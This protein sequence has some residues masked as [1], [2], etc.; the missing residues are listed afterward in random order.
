MSGIAARLTKLLVLATLALVVTASGG[1]A[2]GPVRTRILGV[3]PHLSH[4]SAPVGHALPKAGAIRAVA[5]ATLTFDAN[6][7]RLINQYF[8]DVAAASGRTDNVYSVA[9]Q[10]FDNPG[11]VHIQYESTFGGAAISHDPL[12]PNGCDDG[13]DTYCLTD[14]QL[15]EEIQ[16]VLTAKAWHGDTSALNHMFF[17]MTPNGV[18]SCEFAGAASN[19]N[20]CSTNFFCAYHNNFVDSSGEQVIYANEPYMGPLPPGECTAEGIPSLR[21]Q[22]FPNNDVDAET[23]INTISHEHNEA[24]TDPLGNA[25]IAADTNENGDLCAYIF[26]TQLGGTPGID[27]YN[28]V[29]N[30]H[31]YDLQQ[32]YS[33]TDSGCIQRPN[34]T[35]SAANVKEQLPYN[36][37]PVMHT[38]TTYAIYWLPTPGNTSLPV[39]TGSALV[40]HTL[41]TSAGA[42]NGGAT[43]FHDQWQRCSGTSCVNI[44]GATATTYKLTAADGGHIVRSSVSATNVNGASAPTASAATAV[45]IDVPAATSLP[46]ISGRARVGKKLSGSHG[47]WTYSPASFNVQWLRCN[48]HGGHC[49]SIH[50]AT[51]STYKLTKHDAGHRL[52]LRVTAANA[53]GS[54]VALSKPSARVP[55][56]KHH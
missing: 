29:I 12:P 6:Y 1:N 24:I 32:E 3:V 49:S 19:N 53:A 20:P 8:K 30:G 2:A 45:V 7:E 18:G 36:K 39:V 48:A 9:T 46:H 40:H 10:Y 35:V 42:W 50:H 21:D 16:T 37:G 55:A 14:T 17:L 22:G 25:W 31:R 41:T 56:A 54:T 4:S 51:H 33:N 23:T 5:P 11:A 43:G 15:Q 44:P 47:A 28:Q 38:N 52:R 13:V 27:A 26:G 34:G